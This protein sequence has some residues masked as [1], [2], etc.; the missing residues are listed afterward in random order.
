[1]EKL[2]FSNASLLV[3][4]S[5][6]LSSLFVY[7][8]DA[9]A[10]TNASGSPGGGVTT[11]VVPVITP[12]TSVFD[13]FHVNLTEAWNRIYRYF[14]PITVLSTSTTVSS[15]TSSSTSTSTSTSSTS[16]TTT[17][18]QTSKVSLPAINQNES[19]QLIIQGASTNLTAGIGISGGNQ[20]YSYQWLGSYSNSS[21]SYSSSIG[22]ML[23]GST[24]Q[25]AVCAFQTVSENATLS[26]GA[27]YMKL[28]VTDRSVPPQIVNSS[29]IIVNVI[30]VRAEGS[31]TDD[32]NSQG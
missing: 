2:G 6:I 21:G 30:T 16:S 26:P 8:L 28:M 11:T 24:A 25:S 19:S 1:M 3:A 5:L 29:V 17:I 27:Y 10:A 23:C 4:M 9:Q 32:D 22:D 13:H 15:S 12:P 7:N 14:H 20:P 31:G 18:Y